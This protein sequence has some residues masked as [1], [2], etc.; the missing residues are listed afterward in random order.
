[1]YIVRVILI[2]VPGFIFR[3]KGG[4]GSP[5][6]FRGSRNFFRSKLFFRGPSTHKKSSFLPIPV[7][8]SPATCMSAQSYNVGGSLL[9]R[10]LLYNTLENAKKPHRVCALVI[11]TIKST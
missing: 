6:G 11:G 2:H 3:P 4:G 7:Q 9:T 8:L 5:V 10:V 1:M